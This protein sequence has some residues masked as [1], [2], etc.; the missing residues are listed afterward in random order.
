VI[1][2]YNAWLVGLSLVIAMCASYV[3]LDLAG[4]TTAARGRARVTWLL[5]GAFAMGLGIWSMHY[6]GMLAFTLPVP[7]LYHL[8]T[9]LLSLVAA[10]VASLVALFV[11]SRQR[12]TLLNAVAGSLAM[13]GAISTMHYV[14]MDAMRMSAMHHWNYGIVALSVVIAVVVSLVA[15]WLAFRFR[16][17][18]TLAPLKLASAAVMGVAVCAMHY[19]GMAAVSYMPSTMAHDLAGAVDITSLGLTAIVVVTFMFLAL[20]VLTSIVDRRMSA[21][22][23]V[24]QASEERY[25]LLFNRSLA[26]V[27]QSTAE[28]RLLDCN[29]ALARTFGYSSREACLAHAATDPWVDPLERAPFLAQL[30]KD[31]TVRDFESR[32]RRRD[33]A[34]VWV[35]ENAT[36]VAGQD[37]QGGVIEGML[38][39]ISGRKDMEAAL[40]LAKESADTANRAKSE[41]LANMSHEIRTPMNGVVGMTELALSTELTPEQREYL[42]MAQI[43]ADSLLGL[44]NDILDFSKIEARKLALDVIGFDLRS[45]VDDIMR[46][47][48]PRAHQKGLELAYH[49]PPDVPAAIDGD[50][51]RLRQIVVNLISN[52]VKFTEAGE[53]VLRVACEARTPEAV[54]LRFT[55]SDT[56]IGIPL[57]KQATVFETFTQA[58]ASTTR[59]FGGT[60]LGLAIASE[61]ATL[62]GG[63]IWVESEPGQGSS[64]H[65][66][67]PFPLSST[68]E[69]SSPPKSEATALRAMRVLVVDDNATN[70]WI[71]GD[72]LS[73]WGMQPILVDSGEAALEAIAIGDSSGQSF[74]LI[75]MDFQMPGMNGLQVAERIQGLPRTAPK[76]TIMMLSSVGQPGDALC[77]AAAGVT[78]SLTKPVRQAVLL[79]AM[80]SV[81][82]RVEHKPSAAASVPDAA[83]SGR[84]LRILL[85]EDNPINQLVAIRLLE[86]QGHAVVTVANGHLAVAAAQRDAFDLVLMDVQMP[87]MGGLEAST[88]IRRAEVETGRHVPIVAL[89]AHAMNGDREACL[90]AGMDGH[91]PKPIRTKELI[92]LLESLALGGERSRPA[93]IPLVPA[94]A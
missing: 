51:T 56:G 65:F 30:E 85:A 12:L 73:S 43:S 11:V 2:S 5:G 83:A 90:A 77:Y 62:M 88:L 15:L 86:K 93:P 87:E 28:G 68:L 17:A 46:T 94:S 23:L 49:L 57:D 53:V 91:L 13:G 72:T 32:L 81:L 14:G 60:G 9:V 63:R 33:G 4:R 89:T 25:R 69:E 20:A 67:L 1:G 70:R 76:M 71:L 22:A 26:G 61:L 39:D 18:R 74:P 54:T 41:F 66:T 59:R 48:A 50:P 7:V 34:Y 84:S 35:L 45:L 40:H 44:I 82:G 75:L 38:L 52:A 27:Y 6:I 21:Q 31:R 8:P 10:M 78:C 36:L 92:A 42:E 29:E 58:D 79:E 3:A 64:F 24:L 55:I 37:G 19:T 47:L 80:L 16:D